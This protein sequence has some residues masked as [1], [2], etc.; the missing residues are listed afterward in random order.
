MHILCVYLHINYT[1]HIK[2]HREGGGGSVVKALAAQANPK[3]PC[4][5]W[6]GMTASL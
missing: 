1:E 3:N 4:N 5:R 6:V 2:F